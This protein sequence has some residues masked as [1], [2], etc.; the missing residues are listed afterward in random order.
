[1][2][3]RLL[4]DR[5]GQ[6]QRLP[7][8]HDYAQ[9]RAS[10]H[11]AARW[12]ACVPGAHTYAHV[13]SVRMALR[14][15]IEVWQ[16][17]EQRNTSKSKNKEQSLIGMIVNPAAYTSP[18]AGQVEWWEDWG[19]R[20]A[21]TTA[22]WM[23]CRA[24][25]RLVALGCNDERSVFAWLRQRKHRFHPFQVQFPYSVTQ[26]WTELQRKNSAFGGWELVI[27]TRCLR[28]RVGHKCTSAPLTTAKLQMISAWLSSSSRLTTKHLWLLRLLQPLGEIHSFIRFISHKAVHS[29]TCSP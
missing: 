15:T 7:A 17:R 24:A 25:E 20:R 12:R 16:S 11:I 4:L 19:R 27:R 26:D 13:R 6:L 9:R 10:T 3:P 2:V 8:T 14:K 1:M 28:Y 22:W 23:P 18:G 21:V 5:C 29:F